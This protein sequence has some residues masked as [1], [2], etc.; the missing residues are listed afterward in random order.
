MSHAMF[1]NT[2]ANTNGESLG[3]SYSE[4]S[5]SGGLVSCGAGSRGGRG[6]SVIG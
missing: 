3:P 2:H 1:V 5:W 6:P 4:V